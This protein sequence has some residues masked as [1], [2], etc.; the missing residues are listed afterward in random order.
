M[1]E[2]TLREG[3]VFEKVMKKGPLDKKAKVQNDCLYE[4]IKIESQ[5][6]NGYDLKAIWVGNIVSNLA[7]TVTISDLKN[8]SEW[9]LHENA[10]VTKEQVIVKKVHFL[11]RDP[12]HIPVDSEVVPI[13]KCKALEGRGNDKPTQVIINV[14]DSREE[15]KISDLKDLREAIQEKKEEKEI[16]VINYEY[17]ASF[18]S[19][20]YDDLEMLC[21]TFHDMEGVDLTRP[22]PK[23][24]QTWLVHSQEWSAFKEQQYTLRQVRNLGLRITANTPDQI[25]QPCGYRAILRRLI[26]SIHWFGNATERQYLTRQKQNF[27]G[28]LHD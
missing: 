6:A 8:P 14:S 18:A 23:G 1:K 19:C 26:L 4:L 12:I 11:D 20:N 17:Y 22:K 25:G 7:E 3:M 21:Q 10:S 15:K 28:N 27:K 2:A 16:Q 13:K 5:S 9:R 24:G